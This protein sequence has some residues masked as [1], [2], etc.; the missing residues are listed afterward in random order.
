MAICTFFLKGQCR[1]GDKCRN[2]HPAGGQVQGSFGNQSWNRAASST[3]NN[4]ANTTTTLFTVDSMRSDLTPQQDKPLWPLSSYGAAKYETNLIS[5]LDE[6]YEEMR[7]KAASAIK[8]GNA[9]QYMQ[10]ESE[11]ISNAD[12]VISDAR[13]NIQ[14]AYD[15]ALKQSSVTSMLN[16]SIS[17]PAAS[18]GAFGSNNS[19]LG[20]TSSP[21][22]ANNSTSA[23]GNTSSSAFGAAAG[24]AFGKPSLGQP[25]SGFGQAS[26]PSTSVF[27]QGSQPNSTFGQ[28]ATSAFGQPTQT[29]SAFGQPSQPT[30]VFGQSS[31]PTNSLIKPATT[32]AFG[33][34]AS[35]GPSAF[36]ASSTP[37]ANSSGGGGFAG[38]ANT[39]GQANAFGGA[40]P[41]AFG[42]PSNSTPTATFGGGGTFGTVTTNTTSTPSAF[43]AQASGTGSFG[44]SAPSGG[45][46]GSTAPVTTSAFGSAPPAASAFGSG[47]TP[48][49]PT[50]PTSVFGSAPPVSAFGNNTSSAPSAFGSSNTTSA[51]GSSSFGGGGGFANPPAPQKSTNSAPDFKAAM[52][53][54]YVA[55]KCPYDAQLPGNY[56]SEV[57][58]KD[59]IEVF[60]AEKFEWGKVPDWIPPLELR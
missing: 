41:S 34:F 7:C 1:F 47:S 16:N 37:A 58:P 19:A 40:A 10:Y 12:K 15:Q 23:F 43:G 8:A 25:Q 45:V 38:F 5:G 14:Q 31:Q 4:A 49:A 32:G 17:G 27:G 9:N 59:V 54:S 2:E 26:Q 42:T 11:R 56:L 28:P 20:S 30:S 44:S 51:F 39:S 52:A 36:G 24:S 21:F 13:N 48:A 33:A 35:G 53:K 18:G 22:G 6:S 55:G 50:Q 29:N 60:K 46:F 3:N 57:V